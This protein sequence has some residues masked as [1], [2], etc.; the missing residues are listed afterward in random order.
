MRGALCMHT[1]GDQIP[2]LDDL[3]FD[4]EWFPSSR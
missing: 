1:T 2:D 4:D 3:I